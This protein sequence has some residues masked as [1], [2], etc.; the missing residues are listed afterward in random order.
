MHYK[1]F[2]GVALP[3]PA[4]ELTAR[5]KP[6]TWTKVVWPMEMERRMGGGWNGKRE[7]EK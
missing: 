3:G 2:D 1:A 7:M 4:V 6:L 5:P